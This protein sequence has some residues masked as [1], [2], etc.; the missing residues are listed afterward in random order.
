[1]TGALLLSFL[2]VGAGLF[3]LWPAVV[4]EILRD[5]AALILV[6]LVVV[7]TVAEVLLGILKAAEASRLR[8]PSAAGRPS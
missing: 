6:V 8:E 4:V 7:G 3:T 2:C 1:M 5:H